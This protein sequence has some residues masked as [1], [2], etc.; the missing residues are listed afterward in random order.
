MASSTWVDVVWWY[1]DLCT[2]YGRRAN[3]KGFAAGAHSRGAARV[4]VSDLGPTRQGDARCRRR[5]RPPV[6]RG[7]GGYPAPRRRRRRRP[8]CPPPHYAVQRAVV[9]ILTGANGAAGMGAVWRP[10]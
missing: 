2:I 10:R 5:H 9:S 1:D 8:H 4:V 6:L 3:E 7:Y